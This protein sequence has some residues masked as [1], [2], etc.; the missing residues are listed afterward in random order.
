[1]QKGKIPS[2]KADGQMNSL[3]IKTYLRFLQFLQKLE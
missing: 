2:Y 1:M 3:M